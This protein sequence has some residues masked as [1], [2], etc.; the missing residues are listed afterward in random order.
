MYVKACIFVQCMRVMYAAGVKTCGRFGQVKTARH[1][2]TRLSRAMSVLLET[3]NS[4]PTLLVG[5]HH[6]SANVVTTAWGFKRV[7]SGENA[8]VA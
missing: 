1:S 8:K 3:A 2:A 7:S 4:L 6:R 5:W